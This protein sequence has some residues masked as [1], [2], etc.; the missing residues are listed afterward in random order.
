MYVVVREERQ[1]DVLPVQV[2]AGVVED[3]WCLQ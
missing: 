2:E 3:A 1:I